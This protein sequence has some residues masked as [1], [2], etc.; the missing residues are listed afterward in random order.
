MI[1]TVTDFSLQI[2]I[3]G[4][5][6]VRAQA[7]DPICKQLVTVLLDNFPVDFREMREI[8]VWVSWFTAYSN[9]H[10]Y[11]W[12]F[13]SYQSFFCIILESSRPPLAPGVL[14]GVIPNLYVK[15]SGSSRSRWDCCLAWRGKADKRIFE[16]DK[17]ILKNSEWGNSLS[18]QRLWAAIKVMSRWSVHIWIP[19]L[20]Y[21]CVENRMMDR[22]LYEKA[23]HILKPTARPSGG[24][25]T[26]RAVLWGTGLTGCDSN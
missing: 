11:R 25:N 22:T 7:L 14:D 17:R 24:R 23:S 26:E 2:R 15:M 10:V 1:I 18:W 8:N 5:A 21:D 19:V 6:P 16:A 13:L 9:I 12:L 4:P 20:T 3:F